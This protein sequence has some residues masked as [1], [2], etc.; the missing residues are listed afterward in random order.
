MNPTGQ[1]FS[2]DSDDYGYTL[3]I[4]ENSFRICFRKCATVADFEK[5]WGRKG[6]FSNP[7]YEIPFDELIDIS[8]EEPAGTI[9]IRWKGMPRN[10]TKYDFSFCEKKDNAI[11]FAFLE[12]EL[13]MKKEESPASPWGGIISNLIVIAS[14]LIPFFI[15]FDQIQM[16]KGTG[17]Y[18]FYGIMLILA[19]N[20]LRNL[21]KIITTPSRD[22]RF[23]PVGTS[24]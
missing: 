15:C 7:Q 14:L 24:R 5:E 21:Y 2:I 6:F 13:H 1:L 8:G 23:L 19:G 18:I 12:Q 22:I 9:Y 10:I 4:D 11:F 16:K 17:L 3:L 20:L